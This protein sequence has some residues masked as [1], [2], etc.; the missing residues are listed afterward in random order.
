MAVAVPFLV[1]GER[2]AGQRLGRAVCYLADAGLIDA[3]NRRAAL[4]AIT[5]VHR[6]RDAAWPEGAFVLLLL[7]ASSIQGALERS[8]VP[9]MYTDGGA[10]LS[11]AGVWYLFVSLPIYRFLLLRWL[12][13][14]VLWTTFL[15][16][17]VRA[18]LRLQPSHPDRMGGLGVVAG[19]HQAFGWPI[20]ALGA[21]LAGFLTSRV[22]LTGAPVTD[23]TYEVA[24]FAVL[25][26]LVFLSPLLVF[27][28]P[29]E[30]L[31]RRSD[32][33]YGVAAA[34]FARRYH[35]RWLKRGSEPIP[36]GSEDP[37]SH[38]D[39]DTS[40][41]RS[42]EVRRIPFR[43]TDVVFLFGCAAVPMILFL[44]QGMPLIEIFENLRK[45]LG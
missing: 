21:S 20:F 7:V 44:V 22:Q 10:R 4:G 45:I 2:A 43:R 14:L 27:S 26:P 1:V 5:T 13:H 28:L 25:A 19:A 32:E 9:W 6:L 31:R 37:S 41:D 36:L 12:W 33:E 3:S 17:L 42:V 11:I 29:L 8:G 34:S 40:F 16:L 23:Y 35:E 38:T 39:L 24:V 15:A 18:P 30:K